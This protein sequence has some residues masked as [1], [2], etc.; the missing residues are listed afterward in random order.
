MLDAAQAVMA[1]I[2]QKKHIEVQESQKKLMQLQGQQATANSLEALARIQKIPSEIDRNIANAAMARAGAS[3]HLA[4]AKTRLHD[5]DLSQRTH[6]VTHP[7]VFGQIMRDV[8]NVGAGAAE[9]TAGGNNRS[10]VW[11]HGNIRYRHAEPGT[12]VDDRGNV[13]SIRDHQII[14][15][16]R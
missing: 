1:L 11:P 12:Y 5:L 7:G 10:N 13:R 15:R 2:T 4:S 9:T 3:D 16:A 8:F 6:T 14:R